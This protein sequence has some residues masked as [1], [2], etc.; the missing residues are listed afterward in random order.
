MPVLYT[1]AAAEP[2]VLTKVQQSVA[3]SITERF[4]R[5]ECAQRLIHLADHRY[6]LILVSYPVFEHNC[7]DWHKRSAVLAGRNL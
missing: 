5:K 7:H 2:E 6:V 3:N 1:L 4:S